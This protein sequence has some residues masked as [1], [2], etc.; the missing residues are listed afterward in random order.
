[1]T[2]TQTVEIPTGQRRLTIDV[3]RE[4][5][6]G[7]VIIAFTPVAKKPQAE[8]GKKIRL[9]KEMKEEILSDETV[10]FL[11]GIIHTEMNL[12]EIREERLAKYL[13]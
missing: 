4:I 5:P 7:E 9:T 11:S 13:Q 10:R 6:A 8:A 3:P 12:E 2:I 1:M